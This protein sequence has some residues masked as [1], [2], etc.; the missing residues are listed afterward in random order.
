MGD[1]EPFQTQMST[2]ELDLDSD[3]ALMNRDRGNK[4][5]MED[6]D[7]LMMDSQFSKKSKPFSFSS[8]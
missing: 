3:I 1:M 7:S 2:S 6:E 4:R 8:M 5:A